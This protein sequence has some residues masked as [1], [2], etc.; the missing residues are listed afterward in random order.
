[1]SVTVT[2]RIANWKKIGKNHIRHEVQ[3]AKE[4]VG[5]EICWLGENSGTKQKSTSDNTQIP[6]TRTP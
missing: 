4:S 3:E 1:M 2:E 5:R 6:I